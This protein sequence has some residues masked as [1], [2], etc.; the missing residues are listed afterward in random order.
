MPHGPLRI[1]L[2]GYGFGGRY[3]HAPLIASTAGCIL[4]GV[5]TRSP[6]RLAE[7]AA[8]HPG[9]PHHESVDALVGSGVD[10][11]AVST[12]AGTHSEITDD[13]L[14]RGV[15][16]VCDKPFALDAAAAARSVELA[17][18]EG[19]PLTV[20]QNRRWDSD[21]LTLKGILQSGEIGP[22]VRFESSFERWSPDPLPPASGG[23]LLRD[24]GSH[25]VDQALVLF[26]PARSVSAQSHLV[27]PE[28]EDDFVLALGHEGGMVSRL[29]GAWRHGAPGPRFRVSGLAGAF[30]VTAPMDGQEGAL[31]AGRDP[32]TEGDRWGE[33]PESS[34][35]LLCR[36][37][38]V[39]R[40]ASQRGRW[41]LFYAEFAM[42]VRGQGRVP[43]DPWDAVATAAVLD[44]ARRSAT[45]RRDVDVAR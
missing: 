43:V 11:V 6:A 36:G 15:P 45:E 21:F 23:G 1:G 10:A 35:G 12:P 16:V 33:E 13:L 4:A 28:V 32:R 25:L 44:A 8:D 34:W 31:T 7:L 20:Y 17:E 9:V 41:D 14:R 38:H 3:F 30:L 19:V 2:V 5:V 27:G 42:A 29:S 24:F 18:A 26:G 22:L 40:V 37:D 39:E